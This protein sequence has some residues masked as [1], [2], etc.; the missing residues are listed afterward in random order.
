M[1][2]GGV[3]LAFGMVNDAQFGPIA[4]IAS[5]GRL[6]EVLRDRVFVLA[7]VDGTQTR[8]LIDRL[9]ARPLLDGVRGA[10]AAD[11]AG[12]ADAFARFS[13][14]VATLGDTIGALDVNPV[15]VTETDCIAVDALV[16]GADRPANR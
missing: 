3:E 7:P 13:V 1:I 12:L 15:V 6:I 16:I 11:I 14:L 10:P 9:G 5:S 4:L 2:T 8:R